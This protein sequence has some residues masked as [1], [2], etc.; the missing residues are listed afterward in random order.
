MLYTKN[1]KGQLSERE[2]AKEFSKFITINN[3]DVHYEFA[4]GKVGYLVVLLHGFGAS[5]F[6]YRH[7]LKQFSKYGDVIAY[8]RPCFGLTV[9]P[10][11][12]TGENPYSFP[13][14][15]KLLDGIVEQFGTGRQIILVGHSAGAGIAAE[16][17]LTNQERV[18]GLILEEPAILARPPMPN[19]LGKLLKSR[20]FDRLGPRLVAGF[21][22]T[23]LSILYK[24]W[25]DKSGIT[26]EV[27]ENYQI[28]LK[29]YGWEAAFWEFSRSGVDSIIQDH[30]AEIK[31]PT[32]VFAADQDEIIL[33]KYSI[34]VAN[35]IPTA[36]LVKVS[37]CGHIPHEEKP[38]E[39]MQAVQELLSQR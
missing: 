11:S 22:K 21:Q 14:Q 35:Q 16:W 1:T 5:T 30:L 17:A 7:L 12:W 13:A 4:K 19:A 38:E 24:S 32:L 26:E 25:F 23:G 29:V 33:P 18:A 9:R 10:K 20:L 36:K 15:V 27:L 8:D 3:V 6:S 31:V 34:E 37:E 39:F 28:P 2:L